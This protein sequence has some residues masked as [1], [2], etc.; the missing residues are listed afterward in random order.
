MLISYLNVQ[1]CACQLILIHVD[2]IV[3]LEMADFCDGKFTFQITTT[4]TLDFVC[5]FL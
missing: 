4:N 5:H 3:E 1:A 2:K